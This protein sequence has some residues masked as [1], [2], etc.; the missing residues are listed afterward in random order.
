MRLSDNMERDNLEPVKIIYTKNADKFKLPNILS[1]LPRYED[2]DL[3]QEKRINYNSLRQK[4]S[5]IPSKVGVVTVDE[6]IK[7]IHNEEYKNI[8]EIVKEK[9][10]FTTYVPLLI[11]KEALELKKEDSTNRLTKEYVYRKLTGLFSDISMS[12]DKTIPSKYR[13]LSILFP[14]TPALE[15]Y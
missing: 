2:D 12:Y 10:V 11:L 13:A 7:R 15:L 8:C 3:L 9:K 5:D 4:I 1:E 6:M 14:N